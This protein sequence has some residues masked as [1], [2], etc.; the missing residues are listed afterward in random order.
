MRIVALLWVAILLLLGPLNI[1]L[2]RRVSARRFP[3]RMGAYSGT[4]RGLAALGLLTLLVDAAGARQAIHALL[5]VSPVPALVAWTVATFLACVTVSFAA[6]CLRK[7]RRLRVS[8]LVGLLL[9]ETPRERAAFLGVSLTA[10]LVEEYVMR[11]F[12]LL[13][14]VSWI[15]S[16]ILALVLVSL[17][18]GIA[19]GYQD[20]I[21]MARATL[22][23]ALLAVPVLLTGALLPAVIVHALVDA[24]AGLPSYRSL[25]NRWQLLP[26][27]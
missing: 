22:L 17:S 10:G 19:H 26:A 21:G 1:V 24:I 18:F 2:T 20:W 12:T 3:T 15:R 23:G 14:L 7:L 16:P 13:T 5:K 27:A 25:M 8:P 4:V 11:G 6:L 9:P